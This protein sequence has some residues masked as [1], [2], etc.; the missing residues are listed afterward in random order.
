[1]K[2][3]FLYSIFPVLLTACGF[4]P[5]FTKEN[6]P[7]ES[8]SR[9]VVENINKE[10]SS[11]TTQ[12][13]RQRLRNTL[14]GLNLDSRYK[15]HIRLSEEA[16]NLAYASDATAT[17]SMMRLNAQIII[18]CDGQTI[19]ETKLASVT[20]YSQN[21]NDE[22][23]NQSVTQGAQERLIESLIIDISREMQ[24]FAKTHANAQKIKA[25]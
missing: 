19:Y 8:G 11:Y 16:G 23:V 24:R 2:K 1:M 6:T 20:S 10:G 14:S 9:L 17:R 4:S 13:M 15:I 21:S 25:E 7:S 3:W 22:F 12:M 5:M 18:S